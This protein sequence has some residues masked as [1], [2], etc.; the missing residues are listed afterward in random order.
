MTQQL[1]GIQIVPPA[2]VGPI[3]SFFTSRGIQAS[4]VSDSGEI[5]PQ[6]LLALAYKG[7]EIRSRLF[8][9]P[10]FYDFR[11]TD[12][13]PQTQAALKLAQPA[14]RGLPQPGIP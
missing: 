8:A 5:D 4:A 1:A 14:V 13:N 11:K 3:R 10:I 12:S 7:V 6:A 2:L 9:D